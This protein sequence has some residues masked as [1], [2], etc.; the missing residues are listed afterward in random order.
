MNLTREQREKKAEKIMY[1]SHIIS[2]INTELYLV[3]SESNPD[4]YYQ[5]S[6]TTC[7][8]PY[9][10]AYQ[11]DCKHMIAIEFMQ[12]KAIFPMHMEMENTADFIQKHAQMKKDMRNDIVEKAT[13]IA[14]REASRSTKMIYEKKFEELKSKLNERVTRL[15]D[16]I[17]DLKAKK[18]EVKLSNRTKLLVKKS[19]KCN[20]KKLSYKDDKYGF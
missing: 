2:I 12:K 6:K 18:K 8:C 19:Q 3:E 20:P 10:T 1:G 16:E 11:E 4:V 17:E 15:K 13:K 9:H 14:I 5:T 7:T